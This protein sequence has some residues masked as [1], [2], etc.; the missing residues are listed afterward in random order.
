MRSSAAATKISPRLRG[1]IDNMGLELP[2]GEGYSPGIAL[3]L[4]KLAMK[5]DRV[6]AR[7][8]AEL[9][10]DGR[11]TIS[12]LAETVGLS[13]TP[14]ARRVRQLEAAGVIQSYAAII[15]PMRVGLKVQ[16]FVQVK[17]T[18]HTDDTVAQFQQGLDVLQGVASCYAT[19]GEYDFLLHV[20]ATDLDDLSN[21]VLKR[22]LKIPSV[23]DVHS[24]I[25]LETVKRSLRVPLE[26]LNGHEEA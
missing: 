16:A 19:T 1:K 15:D 12:Q 25:V 4:G 9:Q 23:R 11:R 8:V 5:L 20:V 10:K 21:F 6:D 7:I 18:R 17:L 26:H 22:L 2:L 3:K 24:S 13:D 14:C